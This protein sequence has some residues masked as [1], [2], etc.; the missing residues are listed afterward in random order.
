[1]DVYISVA[2][3]TASRLIFFPWIFL[4]P[5]GFSKDHRQRQEKKYERDVSKEVELIRVQL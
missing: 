2:D 4:H 5:L 1:M 3:I